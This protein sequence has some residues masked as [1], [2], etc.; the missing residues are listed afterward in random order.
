MSE[1]LPGEPGESEDEKFL[2]ITQDS[3]RDLIDALAELRGKVKAGRTVEKS[4]VSKIAVS[5][6][7][8]ATLLIK[9]RLR[10]DDEFRKRAGAVNG[11]AVDLERERDKVR[12]LL[13]R[14]RQSGDAGSVPL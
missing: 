6:G 5:I 14:L 2:G 9:T 3:L 8:A 7:E 10:V 13:D 12:R 4:E 11:Y 1:H